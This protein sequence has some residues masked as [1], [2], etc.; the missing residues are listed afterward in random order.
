MDL[1]MSASSGRAPHRKPYKNPTGNTTSESSTAA[2]A[3]TDG[4]VK[5]LS[6][7]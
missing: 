7:E 4:T 3:L 5:S 1:L 6:E 2:G